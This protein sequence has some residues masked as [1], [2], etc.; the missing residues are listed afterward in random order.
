MGGY[1]SG[2]YGWRG[3][4]EHRLRLSIRTFTGG[5]WLVPGRSGVLPWTRGGEDWASVSFTT[6]AG[7]VVLNY[8]AREGDGPLVPV[9]ITLPVTSIPCRFGGR[10]YYWQ[11]PRCGRRCEGL[12]LANGGRSWGCRQ[13][14]RLRY[15]CQGLDPH[16]RMQ[17]RAQ[18]IYARLDGDGEFL[19]KPK[20]MRWRTFNRLADQA[21]AMDAAADQAF[22]VRC[23]MRFGM[24]PDNLMDELIRSR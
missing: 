22:A 1:G 10:R 23:L 12:V 14:L 4:I 15:V 24:L 21:N 11:C 17:R 3:V 9:Q 19:Q 13:C 16:Y 20:W 8:S 2:R 5:D 18:K 7:A 6:Q